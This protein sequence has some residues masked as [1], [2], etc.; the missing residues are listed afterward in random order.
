MQMGSGKM[1][2]YELPERHRFFGFAEH[3]TLQDLGFSIGSG[4]KLEG[5]SQFCFL[6]QDKRNKH[7]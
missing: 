2:I 1:M 6:T 3:N 7:I 4:L 5:C